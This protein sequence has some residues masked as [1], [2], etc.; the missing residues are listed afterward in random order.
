MAHGPID[1]PGSVANH[2][3]VR[4]WDADTNASRGLREKKIDQALP[5]NSAIHPTHAR[6]FAARRAQ[7]CVMCMQTLPL[8]STI[9]PTHA[10]VYA[11]RRAQQGARANLFVLIHYYSNG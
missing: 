4:F 7:K 10:R 5:L 3:S 2:T 1:L 9:R 8:M 6:V 11:A